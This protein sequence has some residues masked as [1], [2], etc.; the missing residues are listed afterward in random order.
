M[1]I[2]SK[3]LSEQVENWSDVCNVLA[4]TNYERFLSDIESSP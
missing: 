3:P 1:K 2:H 4:G